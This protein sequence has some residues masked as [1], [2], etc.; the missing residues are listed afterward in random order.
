MEKF[1]HSYLPHCVE[2]EQPYID[3]SWDGFSADKLDE[4]IWAIRGVDVKNLDEKGRNFFINIRD[5]LIVAHNWYR[6]RLNRKDEFA[7]IE[8]SLR[9]RFQDIEDS[10]SFLEVDELSEKVKGIMQ[11]SQGDLVLLGPSHVTTYCE[12][13]AL[14]RLS[15]GRIGLIVF[16]RHADFYLQYA[17]MLSWEDGGLKDIGKRNF[18]RHLLEGNLISAVSLFGIP[19]ETRSDVCFNT[20]D[21]TNRDLGATT[22]VYNRFRK[23]ISIVAESL[24][25]KK[26]RAKL[27]RLECLVRNELDFLKKAGVTNILFSVDVDL[28]MQAELGYTAMDY[29]GMAHLVYLGTDEQQVVEIRELGKSVDSNNKQKVDRE[30]ASIVCGERFWK[31]DINLLKPNGVMGRGMKLGEIGRVID[32]SKKNARDL[33]IEIGVELPGGRFYGDVV[34]LSGYDYRGRTAKAARMIADRMRS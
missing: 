13:K 28:L 8:D 19:E 26:G 11:N 4:A 30:I 12:I 5:Y 7:Q 20:W 14:E 32:W 9:R 22:E 3:Y 1:S 16:D 18:L 17:E 6:T 27:E 24:W 33:G 29:N 25:N 34:E 2:A 31:D 10:D 23:R 21:I 15:S